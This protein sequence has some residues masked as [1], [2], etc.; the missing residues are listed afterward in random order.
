MIKN[1]YRHRSFLG[2]RF[3]GAL[4]AF[5]ILLTIVVP[6][7]RIQDLLSKNAWFFYSLIFV[8]AIV[9]AFVRLFFATS[10]VS[11]RIRNTATEVSIVFDDIFKQEG[12]IIVPV[13]TRFRH[14]LKTEH[15]GSVRPG[16]VHGQLIS[17]LGGER[18]FCDAL[19]KQLN[20]STATSNG[21]IEE[22]TADF[23][24]GTV[25]TI[26]RPSVGIKE[27]GYFHLVAMTEEEEKTGMTSTN[28]PIL[29]STLSDALDKIVLREE[30]KHLV[31]PLIGDGYGRIKLEEEN[32]LDVLVATVSEFFRRAKGEHSVTFVLRKSLKGEL[33][34]YNVRSE[35][36]A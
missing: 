2:T 17:H 32:L 13:S 7:S 35:W 24:L 21:L 36:K 1:I 18:K 3:M 25:A 33:K 23:P 20:G 9:W 26:K 27:L 16:S 30:A 10:D 6:T 19:K 22:E 14:R 11:F 34:L 5:A 31:M 15:G 29:V 8:V 12:S 28:L 4:G